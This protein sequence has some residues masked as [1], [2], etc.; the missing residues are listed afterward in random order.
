MTDYQQ[1]VNDYLTAWNA[2]DPEERRAAIA[3]VYTEDARYA[4]PLADVTG[5]D[6]LDA[7][8][9]AAHAQFP[10]FVFAPI[11]AVDGHHDQARFTWGL[12][13]GRRETGGRRLR[14]RDA[15]RGRPDQPGA[16]LPRPGPGRHLTPGVG[17]TRPGPRSGCGRRAGRTGRPARRR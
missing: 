4:D 15:R 12:G 11:G 2:T 17:V 6:Q 1:L 10:G 16:R 5:H 3:R 7:V 13:P 8:M 14:R 9:A